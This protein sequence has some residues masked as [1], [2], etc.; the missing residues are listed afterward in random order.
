MFAVQI[1]K[2]LGAEVTGVSSTDNVD[3]VRALGA[4]HVIDYT[5]DDFAGGEHSYDAI[6]DTGGHGTLSR[7]RRA[8][9][10]RGTLVI[11]GS[12]TSGRWLGGFDRP[13]RARLLS[14]FVTQRLDMLASKENANDLTALRELIESGKVMPTIDRTYPLSETPA[15]IRYM[16]E[17]RARGKVVITV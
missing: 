6:L 3:L 2:A 4:N 13:L 7:L 17:G 8:L 12:E 14:P 11:L 1:A 9:T 10:P 16:Q 15:A 5:R